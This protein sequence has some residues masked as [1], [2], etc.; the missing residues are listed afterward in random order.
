MNTTGNIKYDGGN[1]EDKNWILAEKEFNRRQL[2]KVESVFCQGNGYLGQRGALEEKY[3]TETRGLFLAGTY[4]RFGEE[5]VT[6][7]PNLADFTNFRIF[8]NDEEFRM[9]SGTIIL[10][11]RELDLKN[12]KI[13]RHIYWE[14][15]KGLEVEMTFKRFVS[16][17]D[18]HVL[19]SRIEI[20]PFN[21]DVNVRIISG[22]D[23]RQ[24]NSGTQHLHE[25]S[26]HNIQNRLVE[27]CTVTGESRISVAQY[28]GHRI[29]LNGKEIAPEKIPV[30]ERRYTGMKTEVEVS[31]YET[32]IIDK[33]CSVF[34]SRDSETS[35]NEKIW[36]TQERGR[37]Q[38]LEYLSRG[39]LDLE[40]SN[41]RKWKHYWDKN[42]I[43]IQSDRE[44]DQLAVRFA[45]YHLNIM[46]V[47][48]DDRV[49]VGARGL[50]G[51]DYRGHVF[52]DTEMF[53]LP[54]YLFTEPEQA[55]RLLTYRGKSLP[56]AKAKAYRNGF[57][58]AMF[59][60]ESAGLEDG[61][62]T[63]ERGEADPR[64]REEIQ[65]F[66]GKKE[67]HISADISYAVW[68][69]YK[70]TGDKNFL[71]EWGYEIILATAVFWADRVE[72][73][74]ETCH[75]RDVIGPDEYKER[76]DDN[77]YTNYMVHYNL[78]LALQIVETLEKENP[79]FLEQMNNRWEV[80]DMLPQ[81]RRA[82]D[83]IALAV[84]DENGIFPQFAGYDELK[85]MDIHS[86]KAAGRNAAKGLMKDYTVKEL[87]EF[88]VHKQAD[89]I[90]L[91]WLFPELAGN[92]ENL[93]RNFDFYEERTIHAVP[94]SFAIHSLIAS[95][96]DRTEEA[97][98]LFYQCCA[99]DM[100]DDGED[101]P[102]GIHA[103]CMG[104]IW[105]CIVQGFCGV[106]VK[107][108][109]LVIEPH[110]P[111]HWKSV[112]FRI[113]YGGKTM[114]VHVTPEGVECKEKEGKTKNR[115]K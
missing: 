79:K 5:E 32:L 97:Y 65:I 3:S 110:L 19:A 92:R 59:P 13:T 62:V 52:W 48:D 37:E 40:K 16:L 56:G 88:Q 69:Y 109:E 81:I 91:L 71:Q 68:Q 14:S 4:D 15:P 99:V 25:Q 84:P 11:S 95:R 107:D 55:R 46:A 29:F 51:E 73:D 54:F 27:Y 76:V 75:I 53:L 41:D 90:F 1:R 85:D 26:K 50:T 111:Q 10:Y 30:M 21:Q 28:A 18:K 61:E 8:L 108:G 44:L 102:D 94:H 22:I 17:A 58:G 82:A 105:Q 49:S 33:I 101:A 45:I 115:R 31:S 20:K 63:P 9:V 39:Y 100:G 112:E 36:K 7:L 72:W 2:K 24:T 42:D 83:A 70:V 64:T 34:T 77:T 80:R 35:E 74:G 93:E 113:Q 6:E 67:L 47:R 12:G 98:Q 78:K 60:W 86:Y 23:G 87:R 66:T 43:R 114:D 38:A 96:L 103:A 104:G 106:N 89:L 57:R